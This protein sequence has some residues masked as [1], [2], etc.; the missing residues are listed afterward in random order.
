MKV[1]VVGLG[2]IGL[3]LA[4][5]YASRGME[6]VGVDTNESLVTLV[7]KAIPPFPGEKGLEEGLKNAIEKGGLRGTTDY[8]EAIPH[9]NVIVVVVPLYTNEFGKPDFGWLDSATRSIATYLS[10][11]TVII[12]ETTLPVGTTRD[13]WKP[14]LEELSGLEEGRDF[15]LVFSPERVL[16]GRIFE[17]LK[18]YPKLIGALNEKGAQLA[19][20]FYESTLDFDNRLD[21]QFSNGVWD[22]GSPEAAEMAKLAETTYRDVNIAL[23]NQF[24]SHAEQVGV[25]IYKVIEACNSQPFSHIHLPG[26]A[27]GGHCIPVYPN[28]Y[29]EGDKDAEIVRVGR[30]TNKRMPENAVKRIRS[31]LGH[32]IGRK[33]VIYGASYRSGVKE[34]AFSGV[35][36]LEKLL[37]KAGADVKVLDP[38]FSDQELKQI[39]L[40]PHRLGDETDVLILQIETSDWSTLSPGNFPNLSLIYDGRGFV[41]H[42][43]FP[44]VP[45]LTI[46]KPDNSP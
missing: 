19:K 39:G 46:G 16:S 6:V 38:L 36:P 43:A 9:S 5:Q 31:K 10:R 30:E 7:N 22:L 24:A 26:I 44:G 18:K 15:H 17:D 2:K 33:C 20:S 37:R 32:L 29:L 25:D 34:T 3:P 11:G 41:P 28:L 42:D 13:R 1:S 8:S 21:L 23:A 4:V 40:V 35:F 12:Y 14:M 45:L 27:V